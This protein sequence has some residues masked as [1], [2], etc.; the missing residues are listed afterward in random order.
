[1]LVIYIIIGFI[2]S[3]QLAMT[4]V[5]NLI[6]NWAIQ[7]MERSYFKN[8]NSSFEKGMNFVFYALYG[9]PH[10]V[11]TKLMIRYTYWKARFLF[12][13]WSIAFFVFSFILIVIFGLF[14]E[15]LVTVL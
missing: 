3:I 9:L 13:L 8:P 2:F 11:Y 14:M 7:F 1:M 15:W 10:Y 12:F 4:L 5:A 6:G